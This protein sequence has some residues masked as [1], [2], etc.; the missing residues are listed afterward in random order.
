MSETGFYVELRFPGSF[1]WVT[2]AQAETRHAAAAY[3]GAAFRYAHDGHG[4]P[5]V[6]ARIR[7][8]TGATARI[9]DVVRL[10]VEQRRPSRDEV[11]ERRRQ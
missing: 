1:R 2:V 4:T 3:A 7:P 11:E 5:A 9:D 10:T 6:E 8:T